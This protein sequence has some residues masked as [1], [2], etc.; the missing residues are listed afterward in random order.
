MGKVESGSSG[1]GGTGDDE[2][3]RSKLA[4]ARVARLATVSD[5]GRPHL[6]PVTFSLDGDRI[7]TAVDH[8][9]KTTTHL[10]RLRNI[11]VNP[12][13][14]VLADHYDEDWTRLW[15]VRADG[16][17]TILEPGEERVPDLLAPLVAKYPQYTERVPEGPVI[18]IEVTRYSSWSALAVP[19]GTE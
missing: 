9:P 10:R 5:D 7:V 8:K 18:L 19:A 11:H 1:T 4:G 14:C 15:W 6:V 16:F 12:N 17:A 13:V 3:A 2:L